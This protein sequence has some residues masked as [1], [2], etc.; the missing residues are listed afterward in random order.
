MV[1]VS[2]Y[3]N[4]LVFIMIT[5]DHKTGNLYRQSVSFPLLPTSGCRVRIDKIIVDVE[6]VKLSKL[7]I[8]SNFI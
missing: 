7:L 4:R 2:V 1:K 3:L 8:N 5:V 6:P